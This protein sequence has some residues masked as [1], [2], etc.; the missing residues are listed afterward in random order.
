MMLFADDVTLILAA[1]QT[2]QNQVDVLEDYL[3]SQFVYTYTWTSILFSQISSVHLL[4]IGREFQRQYKA[5]TCMLVVLLSVLNV[6]KLRHD[7]Y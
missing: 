1:T 4:I 2:L 3:R 5:F 7:T 6:G